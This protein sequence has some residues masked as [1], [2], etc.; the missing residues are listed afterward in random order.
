MRPQSSG[1]SCMIWFD[2]SEETLKALT[3]TGVTTCALSTDTGCTAILVEGK[4]YS[5]LAC[6]DPTKKQIRV[7]TQ[8]PPSGP[9]ASSLGINTQKASSTDKD[10]SK[11]KN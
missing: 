7:D 10:S 2:L 8:H 6:C 4:V 9:G 1:A 3:S 11:Q 5:T